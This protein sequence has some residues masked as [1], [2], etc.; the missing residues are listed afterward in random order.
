MP[1]TKE[2]KQ[3]IAID[4]ESVDVDGEHRYVLMMSSA[5]RSVLNMGGLGTTECLK[6]LLSIARK[7]AIH[8]AFG[9]NY[10][11]N[12]MLRDIGEA[13][14]KELWTTN[15]TDW[16]DFQLE[17][18][19]GKWFR[20][21]R[22]GVSIRVHEV[23][24]FFQ[25]S[26]LKTLG[27]WELEVPDMDLLEKMKSTRDVFSP[28]MIT[29][30][31]RYCRLECDVLVRL[32]NKLRDALIDTDLLPSSW[33]GA[34]SIAASM[35][36]N[37]GVKNH[38]VDDTTFSE[39][40]RYA[41]LGGYFGGRTELFAQ[42]CFKHAVEYD[43]RSAYPSYARQLPSLVD[44]TFQRTRQFRDT[45]SGLWYV[46]WILGERNDHVLAPFPVRRKGRIAYPLNGEG[47]YHTIEVA[48]ALE[49]GFPIEVVEG[50]VF[51]PATDVKPFDFLD[52]VY[53]ERAKLK[54]M[55]HAGEKCLKLG[56]NALYGKLAQGVGY[57]GK[58]PPFQ[59]YF[60]A[61]EITASTRAR[62]LR[63]AATDPSNVIMVA[64]DGIFLRDDPGLP[65]GKGL[66][67]LERLQLDEFFTAQPGV[68]NVTVDGVEI[69]K[70]RG[71]FSREIDFVTL[72][73][74]FKIDGENVVGR[75]KSK[76]FIGTGAALMMK[77]RSLWRTW[78]EAERKLSLYPSTKYPGTRVTTE[79]EDYVTH[80]PPLDAGPGASEPYTPKMKGYLDNELEYVIGTEQPLLSEP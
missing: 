28:E 18:L 11:V 67:D 26:F 3:F 39:E 64:T 46:R 50:Y 7:D 37:Q 71:F 45:S 20:V 58:V 48:T 55:N 61:G 13:K 32:M 8:V 60:W 38:R 59:S 19:P 10:D 4:G 74:A 22:S 24:G 14:L 23:F 35:L 63:I 27:A 33:V 52:R 31:S 54:A 44:G 2:L 66:G 41:F 36:R 25:M 12:M 80:L 21:A 77:D 47:W 78:H 5:G 51:Q 68:Y 49:L 57:R 70:S 79:N 75:Y 6:Y 53:K 69:S 65:E 15:H 43:I 73:E 76:R 40:I 30:I 9:L 16:Y 34:G 42:G 17:W 29:E 72:R 1:R 56:A 62:M